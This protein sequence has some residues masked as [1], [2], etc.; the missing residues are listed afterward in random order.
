MKYTINQLEE[1]A[2]LVRYWTLY[3]TTQAGSGHPTSSL[4]AVE[5]GVG[6][7]FGGEFKYDINNSR[8]I[9]NDRFILS[10][11]HASPLLYS[12]WLL[13]GVITPEEIQALR[14]FTSVL[15][16][17]PSRRFM[18]A[19]A[20]TGSLGQ[21]LGI[22][23]GY[24]I[25]AKK[26]DQVNS[27]TYVMLGDSELAEGSVWESVAS[28]SYY[29]LNN[30]I[31]IVDINRL[32]QRGET[33]EG[34]NLDIYQKKFEAF[35]WNTIIIDG[36]N[37]EE[38]INAFNQSKYSDKPTAILAKTVKGKG[39]SL[40]EDKDNWHGKALT[41]EQFDVY[42]EELGQLNL[43]LRAEIEAPIKLSPYNYIPSQ[44]DDTIYPNYSLDELVSPRKAF[45]EAMKIL[46]SNYN[47][48]IVLDAEVSNSTYANHIDE[49]RFLEMFIAEQNMLSV[50]T[51][52]SLAGKKPFVSS[53]AGFLTRAYDQI[54][55]AQYNE[56]NIVIVGTHPGVSIGADGPS[57]MALNDIAFFRGMFG[58]VV[59]YPSDAISTLKLTEQ[60]YLYEGLS[61]LR[62]T[63]ADV[64]TLYSNNETFVVGGSKTIYHSELDEITLVGAGITLY[65]CLKAYDILR[66]RGVSVRVIDL[67]SIKPLD[68]ATLHLA[69]R[70]TKG[71][72]VV[73][74]H[75]Q[76]GGIA[77]AIR[78]E[79]EDV[80]IPIRS[81]SVQE[82]PRSGTPEELLQF[83]QI[84]VDGIVEQ[85]ENLRQ[86]I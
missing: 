81:L 29:R 58:S 33:M 24:S 75:H 31:A 57:Q 74:D 30:L 22:G 83:E 21:G 38:V 51:G 45:G 6:L 50:A 78:S 53:F 77:E 49:N 55:M 23:I 54:R 46:T 14:Q 85:V 15:E 52:L 72:I 11:G 35:G 64:P 40:I 26:F 17:H 79:L 8:D 80:Q 37:L 32:G 71:L 18:F 27:Y 13:A 43:D 28:A 61:Y 59:L 19:D 86:S 63:R 69:A 34:Y 2:K 44:L 4:S 68:T 39:I 9:N 48:I 12:L 36:H 10:K 73:E 70:E 60:A 3:S 62:L 20:A 42:I 1:I 66:E 82:I 84:N 65:E 41:Q 16:G 56:A 7:F 67:Y 5:L 76:A 47:D 25:N